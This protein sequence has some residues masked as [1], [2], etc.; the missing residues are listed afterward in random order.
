MCDGSP[1]TEVNTLEMPADE[2]C[3]GVFGREVNTLETPIDV[4][5]LEDGDGLLGKSV[6]VPDSEVKE[7]SLGIEVN[8]LDTSTD[9]LKPEDGDGVPVLGKVMKTLVSVGTPETEVCDGLLGMEVN[10][11]ETP[12]GL[13][14][15]SA[16]EEAAGPEG[17]T[18]ADGEGSEVKLLVTNG[19]LDDATGTEVRTE[20]GLLLGARGTAL[21]VVQGDQYPGQVAMKVFSATH[22]S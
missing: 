10:T 4:T 20:T 21:P 9:E 1:G 11:L 22:Q 5:K 2:V 14:E 15:G 13:A 17:L 18:D 19:A 7:G 6:V 12:I 8:M 3:S 16:V